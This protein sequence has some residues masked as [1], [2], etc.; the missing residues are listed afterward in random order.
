MTNTVKLYQGDIPGTINKSLS[1]NNIDERRL[2]QPIEHITIFGKIVSKMETFRDI[3]ITNLYNFSLVSKLIV[4]IILTSLYFKQETNMAV[5]IWAI[6]YCIGLGM[7]MSVRY[8][9]PNGQC[10]YMLTA[11]IFYG[12][13]AIFVENISYSPLEM[14]MIMCILEHCLVY[15]FVLLITVFNRF[16][17]CFS[18]NN[19]IDANNIAYQV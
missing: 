1:I 7:E 16:D 17:K 6:L 2:L 15:L 5:C 18:H 19:H 8:F 13:F 4:T 12:I 14:I 9:Y 10:Y 3:F 11:L